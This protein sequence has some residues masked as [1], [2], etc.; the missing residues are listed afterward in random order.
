MKPFLTIICA[1]IMLVSISCG[2]GGSDPVLPSTHDLSGLIGVWDVVCNVNGTLDSTY[3]PMPINDGFTTFW[4]IDSTHILAE[5]G[6]YFVWE[7][8][9]KTLVV[10]NSL[11]DSYQDPDCGKIVETGSMT[12]NIPIKPGEKTAHYTGTMSLNMIT[13]FCGSAN[14]TVAATGNVSK[15]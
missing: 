12:L 15:R 10:K 8:D 5:D 2:G 3:G 14:G 7:Y 4:V 11:T 6:G 9:G 13:E 1:A